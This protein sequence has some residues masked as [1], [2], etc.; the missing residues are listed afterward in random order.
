M[1][2][3]Y[4]FIGIIILIIFLL[5]SYN[6][7]KEG[8][9]T[10]LEYTLP[11][12]AWT[13]WDTNRPPKIIGDI[14]KNREKVMN[15]WKTRF[16]TDDT[17]HEYIHRDLPPNFWKLSAPHRADWIRLAIIYEHGGLWLDAGIIINNVS[18]LDDIYDETIRKKSLFTGFYPNDTT[19]VDNWFIMAPKGS[20]LIREWLDEFE[21]AI[22]VGFVPYK[23][24]LLQTPTRFSEYSNDPTDVYLTAQACLQY[25]LQKKETPNIILH[26]ATFS[27]MKI[28]ADCSKEADHASCVRDTILYD[29][30][31]KRIPFIKLR[32]EDRDFDIASYFLN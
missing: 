18:A 9:Q 29:P 1:Y 17:F 30:E 10:E 15:G 5:Y 7:L 8:F 14:L 2:R 16:V 24:M 27:M 23:K 13:H 28:H 26:N 3:T 31:S 4:I 11:K 19:Y 25:L 12:I 22:T 32:K 21:R 6:Q 20:S